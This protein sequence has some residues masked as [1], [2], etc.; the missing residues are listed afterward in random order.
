MHVKSEGYKPTYLES[1]GKA[2]TA[3]ALSHGIALLAACIAT[4]YLL[5]QASRSTNS[6]MFPACVV[7]M[8]AMIAVFACSTISHALLDPQ[9]KRIVNIYDQ[10]TIYLLIAASYTPFA[11]RYFPEAGWLTVLMWLAAIVGFCSKTF[12]QMRVDGIVLATYLVPS[13]MPIV[14]LPR[15]MSQLSRFEA[16]LVIV[17][18]ACYLAGTPFLMYSH[19]RWFN[20]LIWHV[21][22]ILAT[23]GYFSIIYNFASH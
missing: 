9:R 12:W 17:S 5:W 16:A 15:L 10:A 8:L 22:V 3:N 23:A 11:L 2:E 21:L 6:L 4:P 1:L 13:L 19:K 14:I 7:Y 18:G 20:H